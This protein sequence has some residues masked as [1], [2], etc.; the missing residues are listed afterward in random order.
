[1]ARDTQ[2]DIAIVY[3]STYGRTEDAA[4]RIA[5]ELERLTGVRPRLVE[6]GA[7]GVAALEGHD[8]LIL[9]CSTWN[10]GELQADWDLRLPE[11]LELDLS[12]KLVALFGAG[13]ALAYPDTFQDAIGLL[14]DACEARGARLVGAWLAD[15]YDFEASRALRG[16]SF[17]GLALDYDNQ[18]HLNDE[19]IARWCESLAAELAVPRIR[20]FDLD[21]EGHW[22]ALL[23]CG[24]RQHVR[25]DPPLVERRWVLTEEG[26]AG[27]LGVE[28][29]CVR[30]ERGETAGSE[31]DSAV[32]SMA[33][34][35]ESRLESGEPALQVL[36]SRL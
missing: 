17:V 16:T 15:G 3:G 20:G 21:A 28:L 29:R 27:R 13:D 12:G 22:V 9:G 11:L 23:S 35:A 34:D 5:A 32:G 4:E 31:V 25:H 2:L 14:G 30:C 10:G 36:D 6:V 33:N 19:R 26:R 1:M 7:G 8:V 18:E 24:H